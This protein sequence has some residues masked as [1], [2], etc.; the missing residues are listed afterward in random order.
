MTGQQWTV[1]MIMNNR[2]RP[3]WGAGKI[4]RFNPNYRAEPKSLTYS[5]LLKLA[6]HCRGPIA[7]LAPRDMIDIYSFFHVTCG[8]YQRLGLE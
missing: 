4:V 7:H 2:K 8:G 3:G 6:E 1:G 5:S